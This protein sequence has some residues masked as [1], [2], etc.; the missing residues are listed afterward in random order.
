M[1]C[2]ATTATASRSA[3]PC[4]FHAMTIQ[5]LGMHPRTKPPKY[6]SMI[7]QQLLKDRM[8]QAQYS[9]VYQAKDS[10]IPAKRRRRKI[11]VVE[12]LFLP[13]PQLIEKMMVKSVNS[14]QMR[15]RSMV[16]SKN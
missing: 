14:F 13:Y 2:V 11:E 6:I 5:L 15:F 10:N 4:D 7:W 8:C 16:P 9:F 1:H 3:L 12:S